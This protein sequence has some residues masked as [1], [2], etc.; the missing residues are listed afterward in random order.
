VTRSVLLWGLLEDETFRSVVLRLQAVGCDIA[1]INHA[2]VHQTRIQAEVSNT[3]RYSVTWD[4][5]FC[6]LESVSAAYLRPYDAQYYALPSN[7]TEARDCSD[8]QLVHHLINTWAEYSPATIINR[9]SAEGTNHS[10]L[11]QA[12]LIAQSGFRTPESL[13]TNDRDVA[14]EFL[15]TQGRVIYKSMSSVRSI[16][17]EL[18]G[19][20]LDGLD[21]GPVLFQ[22]L[23]VGRQVRVH[24]VADQCFACEIDSEHIDYRYAPNSRR[25]CEIPPAVARRCVTL[26]CALG[27]KLSGL[28]LIETRSGDWYCLEVNTNPGFSYY[29]TTG[30]GAIAQAV[31]DVLLRH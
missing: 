21:L 7:S 6:Q 25:R 9:P 24:V 14:L 16:V 28:D 19:G 15:A 1:F 12:R 11:F 5:G 4:S 2:A 29:E 22:Q 10:K 27:L 26:A 20:E 13:I 17:K 23:I 18:F 8:P 30:G 3:V 31:A